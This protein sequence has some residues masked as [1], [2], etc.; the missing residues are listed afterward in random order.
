MTNR[1]RLGAYAGLSMLATAGAFAKSAP[2]AD[3][4]PAFELV[5]GKSLPE[6]QSCYFEQTN[7]NSRIGD[8]IVADSL[9]EAFDR[10]MWPDDVIFDFRDETVSVIVHSKEKRV[11]ILIRS[12][13][14]DVRLS[15]Q[16]ITQIARKARPT[17]LQ[18]PTRTPDLIKQC[19]DFRSKLET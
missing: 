12:P 3:D 10:V 16:E 4:A 8:A 7:P 19:H 14:D 6:A 9:G 11:E 15:E 17:I 1:R 2:P 5:P 18:L 13:S